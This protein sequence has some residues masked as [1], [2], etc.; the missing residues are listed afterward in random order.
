MA[1]FHL[2]RPRD[3]TCA[4]ASYRS[5]SKEKKVPRA[6]QVMR[7]GHLEPR[8]TFPKLEGLSVAVQ[9]SGPDG[10]ELIGLFRRRLRSICAINCTRKCH[11]TELCNQFHAFPLRLH[12]RDTGQKSL[13]SPFGHP[14]AAVRTVT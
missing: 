14:T 10:V 1:P 8:H 3:G 6:P 9:D 13:K 5:R 7:D 2:R 12:G 11:S 4:R